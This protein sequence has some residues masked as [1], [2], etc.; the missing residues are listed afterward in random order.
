[1]SLEVLTLADEAH[2][3]SAD[4]VPT[5]GFNCYRFTARD[6]NGP[7][8]V[9]WSAPG[10]ADGG[11]KPSGSGIPLLFPFAGRIRGTAFHFRASNTRWKLATGRA[12]PFTGSCSIGR[13][14]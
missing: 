5:L 4:I 2:G 3:T 13:G 8:E 1:M 12:T 11:L 9:L 14:G 10:F 7:V 6:A